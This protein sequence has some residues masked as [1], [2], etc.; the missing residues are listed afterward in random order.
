MQSYYTKIRHAIVFDILPP[1]ILK[2]VFNFDSN[3]EFVKVIIIP[4]DRLG[5]FLIHLLLV[6]FYFRL[7]HS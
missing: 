6:F 1:P 2:N 4:C 3:I 5:K 7:G